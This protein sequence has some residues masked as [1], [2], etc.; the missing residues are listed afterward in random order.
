M[1]VNPMKIDE[2]VSTCQST[3]HLGYR[4]VGAEFRALGLL[5]L[6]DV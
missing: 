4:N 5:A 1:K 6:K 3:A 2:T